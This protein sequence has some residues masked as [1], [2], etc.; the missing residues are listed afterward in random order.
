M[1]LLEMCKFPLLLLLL[2]ALLQLTTCNTPKKS[3][4][5]KTTEIP[6]TPTAPTT[7]LPL[8]SPTKAQIQVTSP[9]SAETSQQTERSVSKS[10]LKPISPSNDTEEEEEE[11]DD[12]ILAINK[13]STIYKDDDDEENDSESEGKEEKPKASSTN[14]TEDEDENGEGDDDDSCD[15]RLSTFVRSFDGAAYLPDDFEVLTEQLHTVGPYGHVKSLNGTL[16]ILQRNAA[17]AEKLRANKDL[18]D[19]FMYV[20]SVLSDKLYDAKLSSQCAADLLAI[21]QAIRNTEEWAF[22]CK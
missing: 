21:G 13:K 11:E 14:E 18:S 1:K 7:D 5:I 12:S 20:S 2:L 10:T 4:T 3:K 6:T 9:S 17:F 19:T 22:R 15:S 8:S 16:A